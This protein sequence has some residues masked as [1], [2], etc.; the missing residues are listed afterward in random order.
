MFGAKH[1]IKYGREVV[2]I[3]PKTRALLVFGVGAKLSLFS[4]LVKKSI[5]KFI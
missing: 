2:I 1:D 3:I 4:T 5:V